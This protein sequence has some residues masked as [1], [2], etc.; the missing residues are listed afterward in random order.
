MSDETTVGSFFFEIGSIFDKKGFDD[1]IEK[2][3]EASD[4]IT[5]EFKKVTNAY[6]WSQKLLQ[7]LTDS[8]T[9]ESMKNFDNFFNFTSGGFLDMGK[10]GQEIFNNLKNTVASAL[11]EIATNYAQSLISTGLGAIGGGLFGGLGGLLGFRRSGGPIAQSGPYMLHQ[12]E[13]VLPPEVVRSI[14]ESRAPNLSQALPSGQMQSAPLSA[15]GANGLNITVNTPITINGSTSNPQDAR[16]LCEEISSA[17]RRGVAEANRCLFTECKTSS[18]PTSLPLT[19]QTRGTP[20][21]LR[22]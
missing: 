8:F 12:G 13:F 21:E 3:K 2:S 5:E 9:K 22:L 11:A 14:K 20:R 7:N 19:R 15:A 4:I 16:R 17:A 18:K 1:A 10:L 6:N